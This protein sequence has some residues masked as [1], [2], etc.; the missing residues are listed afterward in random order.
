MAARYHCKRLWCLKWTHPK[1]HNRTTCSWGT[2][3]TR[4]GWTSAKITRG[5]VSRLILY[6][7]AFE[8]ENK[9]KNH[10]NFRNNL[11]VLSIQ[12]LFCV[13]RKTLYKFS[14]FMDLSL[15]KFGWQD[16]TFPGGIMVVKFIPYVFIISKRFK[17]SVSYFLWVPLLQWFSISMLILLLRGHLAVSRD[18]FTCHSWGWGGVLLA[19][20]G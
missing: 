1:G 6:H 17:I 4:K 10:H 13:W 2:R 12:F 18:I 15:H 11:L 9:Q 20:S 8:T 16:S 19:S 7:G 14:V 3:E 5:K